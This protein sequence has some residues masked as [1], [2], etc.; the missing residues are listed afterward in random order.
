M[1]RYEKFTQI[2]MSHYGLYV[3]CS[4]VEHSDI[5]AEASTLGTLL[6]CSGGGA[7]LPI[8]PYILLQL[9]VTVHRSPMQ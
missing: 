3:Q 7:F 1:S 4:A 8:A 9:L 5:R 6:C 2:R